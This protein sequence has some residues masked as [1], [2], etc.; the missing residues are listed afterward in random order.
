MA[1]TGVHFGCCQIARTPGDDPVNV[2][3]RSIWSEE[4]ASNTAS[5]NTVPNLPNDG[6]RAVIRVYASVAAYV[7]FG[8]DPDPTTSP[9][10]YIRADSID[11][12]EVKTGDK[13]AWIADT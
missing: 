3:G 9:R 6:N 10:H 11:W 7:A 12:F 2:N 8:V 5:T 13:A 1:L 4:T